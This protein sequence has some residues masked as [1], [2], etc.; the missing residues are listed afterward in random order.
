MSKSPYDQA[1]QEV[2]PQL[3]SEN[4]HY[5]EVTWALNRLNYWQLNCFFQG[6]VQAIDKEESEIRITDSLWGESTRHPDSPHKGD[7]MRKVFP[8]H[9]ITIVSSFVMI[10]FIF[11]RK[12]PHI[13][14]WTLL[15][16]GW[17]MMTSSNGNIFRVTGHLCGE[18]TGD[19][20]IP[21]KKGQWLRALMFSLFFAWINGWANNGE[22]GDL[23]HHRAHYDVTVMC[24]CKCYLCSGF[25]QLCSLKT[26][27]QR[28]LFLM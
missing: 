9:G 16:T 6:H 4:T 12:L 3:L 13:C 21:R 22:A 24:R 23:R 18:F 10:W 7:V 28:G 17:I 27:T 26:E 2:Y 15:V 20:W 8:S 14:T 19:R 25:H 11:S 1:K 5:D